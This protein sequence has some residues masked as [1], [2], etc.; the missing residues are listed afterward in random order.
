MSIPV[1]CPGCKK[2][3]R[4]SDKFAGKSGACPK[5]K[6]TINVP[7]K[8]A[9]IQVHGPAVT[10]GDRS[11]KPI[12]RT[13]TMMLSPAAITA[14]GAASLCVL[15]V[16]WVGG[17]ALQTS[18]R[19]RIIGLLL[20]SPPLVVAAYSFM[21]NDELEPY[22]GVA[23]WVRSGICS[24]GYVV[25]WGIFGYVA[26]TMLTGELWQ[27]LFVA[28]PLLAIGGAI[29]LVCLDLDYGSGFFHYVFY[30]LVTGLLRWAA[31]MGWVWE[32]A[33]R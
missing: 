29:P 4:V 6:T 3:F 30:V 21:R 33:A 11:V 22:Q 2:S 1:V 14:I 7:D 20:V 8:T 9:K 15:L 16:A 10:T 31:G 19:L 26:A 5:C 32:M 25:L 12:L 28:P 24:I 13:E 23:L 17:G 18:L 27:W